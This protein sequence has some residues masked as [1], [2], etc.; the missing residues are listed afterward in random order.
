MIP[1]SLDFPFLIRHSVFSKF[2]NELY[3]YVVNKKVYILT[4][5]FVTFVW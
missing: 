3:K 1:V 2:T 5:N 4:F